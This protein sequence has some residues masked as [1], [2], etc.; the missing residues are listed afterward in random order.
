MKDI[1][2]KA[3]DNVENKMYYVGEED[4]IL[5]TLNDGYIEAEKII[6]YKDEY[7]L[8]AETEKLE[9]L[10]YLQYTNLDDTNGNKIYEKDLAY[11]TLRSKGKTLLTVVVYDSRKGHYLY[12]PVD[13]YKINAGHGSYTG[14]DHHLGGIIEVVGSLYEKSELLEVE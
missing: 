9:H 2:Y 1:K 11:Y 13:L 10:Q 14:F 5:F 4:D 12:C 6:G 8:E 7:P 3:W